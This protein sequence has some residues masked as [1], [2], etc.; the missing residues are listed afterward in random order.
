MDKATDKAQH[1]FEKI[2]KQY[3]GPGGGTGVTHKGTGKGGM[4]AG[5]DI[6]DIEACKANNIK[7]FANMLRNQVCSSD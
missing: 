1:I 2:A 7:R 6:I 5:Y 3:V 4:P